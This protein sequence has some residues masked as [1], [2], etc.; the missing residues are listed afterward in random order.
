[1]K[2]ATS[3]APSC[4]MRTPTCA[5]RT[6]CRSTTGGW[7]LLEQSGVSPDTTLVFYGYGAALGFWLMSARGHR[8]VRML[9][10]P[11][12]RWTESGGA[13]SEEA[14]EVEQSS[15]ELSAES[16]A[17]SASRRDLEAAI[18]DPET[19]LLDVRSELE[20][21]GERFW[22]S[23]ATEGAGA[24][25]H[26]PGAVSVPIDLLRLPDASLRGAAEMRKALE[27]RGV[28]GDRAI[29]TYCTIGNRASL[30]WV[31]MK[32]VLGYPDVAVYYPSWVEWGRE[33]DT[34]IE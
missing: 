16:P 20:F 14:S 31:G 13:W 4:G 25:G 2:P 28:D 9:D 33:A 5:A 19:I 11:R 6:I 1:M 3:R 8:D 10:G 29:I 27:E 17:I 32:H 30:A 15:Y 26:L 7:S 23:G 12:E 34:P 22:P 24:P 21:E 18:D